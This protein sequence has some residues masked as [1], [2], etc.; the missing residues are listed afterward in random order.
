MYM[1]I[2][3]HIIIG[4]WMSSLIINH[5]E[6]NIMN[7][8]Q[9]KYRITERQ[10]DAREI[11][12]EV[13]KSNSKMKEESKKYN[14]MLEGAGIPLIDNIGL[15]MMKTGN[16]L[17]L[18]NAIDQ[19]DTREPAVHMI[20]HYGDKRYYMKSTPM[21][22][23]THKITVHYKNAESNEEE[24]KFIL[25]DL[26]SRGLDYEFQ[27]AY[28]IYS[29]CPRFE[30]SIDID[31]HIRNAIDNI[32]SARSGTTFRRDIFTCNKANMAFIPVDIVNVKVSVDGKLKDMPFIT[33]MIAH[34]DE[35]KSVKYIEAYTIPAEIA[36][37]SHQY[38]NVKLLTQDDRIS[39]KNVS[40]LF[41]QYAVNDRII[42][43]YNHISILRNVFGIL[44]NVKTRYNVPDVIS[45]CSKYI[46][47]EGTNYGYIDDYERSIARKITYLSR[48]NNCEV[49]E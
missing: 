28:D 27:L 20:T 42:S 44:M 9:K 47:T 5:T 39:L 30:W 45:V 46:N 23:G 3:C 25:T 29:G 12:K 22:N 4:T 40:A 2:Q 18:Y 43:P 19:L 16:M 41:T 34:T 35:D 36:P 15:W 38:L 26:G 37:T 6:V 8:V 24:G 11:E 13:E 32:N 49:A 7:D 48:S 21:A 14:E 31:T 33:G 10:F 17:N 1:D